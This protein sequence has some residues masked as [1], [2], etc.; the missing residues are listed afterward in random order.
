MVSEN[1]ADLKGGFSQGVESFPS[2]LFLKL[3]SH[4]ACTWC[5][6]TFK[7]RKTLTW[8]NHCQQN[9]KSDK[10]SRRRNCV[11]PRSAYTATNRMVTL[12][13]KK[14]RWRATTINRYSDPSLNHTI[15]LGGKNSKQKILNQKVYKLNLKHLLFLFMEFFCWF[16][17]RWTLPCWFT[18]C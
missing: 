7:I 1:P 2:I 8:W 3:F 4:Q 15:N 13:W 16:N 5:H 17:S 12:C 11:I 6:E 9:S 18:S 14:L 10:N